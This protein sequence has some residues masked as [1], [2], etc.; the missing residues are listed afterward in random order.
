MSDVIYV[1]KCSICGGDVVY[2]NFGSK[3]LFSCLGCGGV[4]VDERQTIQMQPLSIDHMQI[5]CQCIVCK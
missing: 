4:N 1:G 2:N 3:Y 5:D